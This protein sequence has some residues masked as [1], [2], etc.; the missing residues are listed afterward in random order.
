MY[1]LSITVLHCCLS[2][3]FPP[4][5]IC[6]KQVAAPLAFAAPLFTCIKGDID[7]AVVIGLAPASTVVVVAKSGKALTC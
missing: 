1:L 4:A 5:T 7:A 6:Q 2:D 3:Y